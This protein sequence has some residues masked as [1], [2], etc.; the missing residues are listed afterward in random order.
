MRPGADPARI[1]LGF[2][3][4]HKVE[5]DPQGDLVL[6]TAHGAIRHRKPFIYQ[7]VDGV[8]R[9]PGRLCAG[10]NQSGGLPASRLRR[11]PAAGYRSHARLFHVPRR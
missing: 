6:S 11:E 2:E 3:G 4:A 5:V 1:V 10:R 8:R 7:E 9:N